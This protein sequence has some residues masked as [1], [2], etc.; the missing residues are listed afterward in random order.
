MSN[1]RDELLVNLTLLG[2][3]ILSYILFDAPNLVLYSVIVFIFMFLMFLYV[4]A[5]NKTSSVQTKNISKKI[6][7]RLS[8]PI[9]AGLI[10]CIILKVIATLVNL[11]TLEFISFLIFVIGLI[12]LSLLCPVIDA[13]LM[14]SSQKRSHT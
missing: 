4:F 7:Y 2:Q 12:V 13:S 6:S 8:K 14:W 9:I 1:N 3:L 10:F 11:P 5:Q